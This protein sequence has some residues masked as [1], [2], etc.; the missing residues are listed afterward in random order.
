MNPFSVGDRVTIN[1]LTCDGDDRV[2]AVRGDYCW[3]MQGE[4]EA[5][6]GVWHYRELTSYALE[7]L[8]V[9]DD[10]TRLYT[11]TFTLKNTRDNLLGHTGWWVQMATYLDGRKLTLEAV[12]AGQFTAVKDSFT[13]M[14]LVMTDITR[15]PYHKPEDVP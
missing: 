14:F 6:S 1:G 3:V 4:A 9:E 15:V 7:A 8:P 11:Y 12:G 13:C 5:E 10:T 2:I